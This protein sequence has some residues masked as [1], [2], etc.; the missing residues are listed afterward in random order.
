MVTGVD[1]AQAAQHAREACTAAQQIAVETEKRLGEAAVPVAAE[2]GLMGKAQHAA[3]RPGSI[4]AAVRCPR[5]QVTAEAGCR[6][7]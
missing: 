2:P 5:L 1:A 3:L 6:L 7:T 4:P